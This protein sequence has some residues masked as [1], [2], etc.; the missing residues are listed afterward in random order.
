LK[1]G[2]DPA[3]GLANLSSA[4]P[5]PLPT[6]GEQLIDGQPTPRDRKCSCV[7]RS[8]FSCTIAKANEAAGATSAS[9]PART[10]EGSVHRSD[11]HGA[12]PCVL[13][14]DG[15]HESALH[16]FSRPQHCNP[17][18]TQRRRLR[19]PSFWNA[20][21]SEIRC[22]YSKSETGR[23]PLRSPPSCGHVFSCRPPANGARRK[24][25]GLRL[26]NSQGTQDLRAS[27]RCAFDMQVPC[28][29][30]GE[31]VREARSDK[32]STHGCCGG[33]QYSRQHDRD[34]ALG[35][36]RSAGSWMGKRLSRNNRS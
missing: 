29:L 13:W 28:A 30:F 21:A 34:H 33:A 8:L 36:E 35:P 3:Y 24:G 15:T 19:R 14:I 16:T 12:E 4:T 20:T 25:E 17:A 23:L 11:Q 27:S 5:S 26:G 18:E 2:P 1:K 32:N 7:R 6:A 10:R 22:R 31:G 9:S